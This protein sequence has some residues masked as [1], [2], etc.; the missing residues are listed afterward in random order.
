[1]KFYKDNFLNRKL[2]RV[3]KPIIMT[4]KEK[5]LTKGIKIKVNLPY[6]KRR[7]TAIYKGIIKTDNSNILEFKFNNKVY[8]IDIN[9]ANLK[10]I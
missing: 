2:K 10:I 6:S 4:E 5:I 9:C 7:V 8:K 3:G 1:M